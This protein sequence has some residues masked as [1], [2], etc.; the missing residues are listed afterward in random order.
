MA[1]ASDDDGQP[2][3]PDDSTD[4]NTP[5]QRRPRDSRERLAPGDSQHDVRDAFD[6]S[7][8]SQ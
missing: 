2:T 3:P 4:G 6:G 1:T 7:A 8:L 5:S